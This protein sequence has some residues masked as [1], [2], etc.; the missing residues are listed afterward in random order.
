[1]AEIVIVHLKNTF[2][3][4]NTL[5]SAL[6][7]KTLILMKQNAPETDVIKKEGGNFFK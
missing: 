1:M 6:K 2:K 5:I 4:L 7:V 3:C